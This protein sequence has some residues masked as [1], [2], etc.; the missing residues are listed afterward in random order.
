MARKPLKAVLPEIG[1]RFLSVN[2]NFFLK[3]HLVQVISREK[4]A[5]KDDGYL[6]TANNLTRYFSMAPFSSTRKK[7]SESTHRH[8]QNRLTKGV[9]DSFWGS[10]ICE[11]HF[12]SGIEAS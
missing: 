9:R 2:E 4:F 7:R 3:N 8:Y 1:Q 12:D 6:T 5:E 11:K 10:V